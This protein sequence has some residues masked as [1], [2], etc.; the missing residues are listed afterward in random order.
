LFAIGQA[1]VSTPWHLEAMEGLM[2]IVVDI[3]V[4]LETMDLALLIDAVHS[5]YENLSIAKECLQAKIDGQAF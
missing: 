4:W 3:G 1:L 2:G 5:H